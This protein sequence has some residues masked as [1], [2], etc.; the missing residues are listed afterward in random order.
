MTM[1]IMMGAAPAGV[2]AEKLKNGGVEAVIGSPLVVAAGVVQGLPT[3]TAGVSYLVS[4]P[5]ADAMAGSGRADLFRLP[6][7]ASSNSPA[8]FGM[9]YLIRVV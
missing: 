3:Q 1:K 8:A 2:Y 7:D 5:V 4:A 9:D 6:P